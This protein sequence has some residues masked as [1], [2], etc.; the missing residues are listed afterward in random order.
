DE[1]AV[2]LGRGFVASPR[3]LFLRVRL[4][5]V[6]AAAAIVGLRQGY[7]LARS[8]QL[9]HDETIGDRPVEILNDLHGFAGHGVDERVERHLSLFL[10]SSATE[11]NPAPT[12][13]RLSM[14]RI[15]SNRAD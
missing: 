2:L 8:R 11:A 6:G 14:I 3:S 9:D 12:S 7:P 15:G 4:V 13:I 5:G 1:V 10:S